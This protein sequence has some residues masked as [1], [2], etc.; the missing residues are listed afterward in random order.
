MRREHLHVM[1]IVVRQYTMGFVRAASIVLR[2]NFVIHGSTYCGQ[3]LH[4]GLVHYDF[5][6][7]APTCK[8]V[9]GY[10]C[11]GQ[12]TTVTINFV[13][14]HLLWPGQAMQYEFNNKATAIVV[15]QC[16]M[17]RARQYLLWQEHYHSTDMLLSAW[18]AYLS[19]NYTNAR[20][21][22]LLPR[23]SA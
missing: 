15:R 17:N 7:V 2:Q 20:D 9:D 6:D 10:C 14:Q 22:V 1:C 23:K 18:C 5:F 13:R 11:Q 21:W 4:Y 3:A 19:C 16:T 8:V 12:C